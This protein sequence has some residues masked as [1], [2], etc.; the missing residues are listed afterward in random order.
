[1]KN[2]K[3]Y[4][5][6][7]LL[8]AKYKSETAIRK[9]KLENSEVLEIVQKIIARSNKIPEIPVKLFCRELVEKRLQKIAKAMP[10][11]GYSM[12]SSIRILCGKLEVI[13]DRTK[14]YSKSCKYKP[15][16]GGYFERI[17][18]SELR[19]FH[20]IGGLVT[21]IP[22]QKSKVKKCWW[23]AGEGS[24]N[25]WELVKV[26]GFICGD[27]HSFT[28][29]AAKEGFE[30]AEKNRKEYEKRQILAQKTEAQ[31]KKL[32]VSALR[33]QFTFQDSLLAGNCETGTRAFILRC[34][35]DINK[36]YRGKFLLETAKEKSTN[37]VS[38][39]ER[40]IKWKM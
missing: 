20:V 12:G 40:M 21:F 33:K 11:E 8:V 31:K 10:D 38:Y 3:N 29:E 6:A 37:S 32:F 9:A 1:M 36:K 27:Y 15:K 14:E 34:G 2:L 13:N 16:H 17:K 7:T 18:M 25:R 39:V 5:K 35:L 24:K 22:Q 19:F 23:Y 4:K 28:K 30:R 26:H